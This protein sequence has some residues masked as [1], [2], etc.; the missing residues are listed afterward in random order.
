MNV[1]LQLCVSNEFK[2]HIHL[3]PPEQKNT[4]H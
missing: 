2:V 1:C 4:F 3:T